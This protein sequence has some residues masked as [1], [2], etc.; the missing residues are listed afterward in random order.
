MHSDAAALFGIHQDPE[1]NRYLSIT[2]ALTLA[3]VEAWIDRVSEEQEREGFSSWP[4]VLK[5]TGKLIGR[6]GLERMEDGQVAVAWIFAKDAW[7]H[8]YA[9][10][11]GRATLDFGLNVIKLKRIIALVHPLN[12]ASVAVTHR[13]GMRFDRVV[14][15]YKRDL[16]RYLA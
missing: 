5:E 9:S 1:V 2:H 3:R 8:G 13:L 7:G 6:C 10:E 11:A 16:L 15:A 14:R 12:A 4:V